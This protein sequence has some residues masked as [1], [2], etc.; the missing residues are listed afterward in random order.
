MK[1]FLGI[2]MFT[3][4]FS[5]NIFAQSSDSNEQT[6]QLAKSAVTFKEL[7]Y[8]FKT[9]EFNSDVSHSFI[10]TNSSNSPVSINRVTPSCGCTTTDYTKGPIMPGKTGTVSIKYDSSREGYFSKS[11][12]VVIGDETFTLIFLG[13]VKPNPVPA[14]AQPQNSS[15][16]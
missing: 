7:V 6:P 13:T 11:V 5:G 12:A 10:F 16:Y 1:I 8:N 15:H 9:V 3:L 2:F 14:N 4:L